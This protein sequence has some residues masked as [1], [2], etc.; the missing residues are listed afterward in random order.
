V[1]SAKPT[2]NDVVQAR[3]DRSFRVV[4]Y[5]GATSLAPHSTR[6]FGYAVTGPESPTLRISR[7]S[8][9]RN[10]FSSLTARNV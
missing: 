8:P 1:I 10:Y 4:R 9:S 7:R 2:L 5:A 3:F 6:T